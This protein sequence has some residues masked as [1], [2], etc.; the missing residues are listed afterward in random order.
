M[1]IVKKTESLNRVSALLK[2][3]SQGENDVRR[4]ETRPQEDV[5]KEIENSLT[6]NK[7]K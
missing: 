6:A 5:F 1:N 3:I 4:G 2:L 7:Q